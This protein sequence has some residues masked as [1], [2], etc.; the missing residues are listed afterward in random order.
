MIQL[1]MND[2]N[3]TDAG[4]YK[5]IKYY[6][7]VHKSK[8]H[9]EDCKLKI[10][11]AFQTKRSQNISSNR[12]DGNV[13]LHHYLPSRLVKVTRLPT[14][15]FSSDIAYHVYVFTPWYIYG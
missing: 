9:R 13:N 7:I 6:Y 3:Y 11:I 5:H 2:S 14:A 1:N 10:D 8:K 4:F 15:I 12:G